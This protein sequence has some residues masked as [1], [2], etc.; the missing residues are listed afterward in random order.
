MKKASVRIETRPIRTYK[1]DKPSRYPILFA[2]GY[3][4]VYPY[5]M[6][7][8]LLHVAENRPYK[9]IVLENEYV[10]VTILPE[11]GGHL[12]SAHDKISGRDLFYNNQV[13]K[14]GLIALR[15]AWCATGIEWNFPVGHSVSTVSPVDH[16][17]FENADG[18]VTAVV[19]DLDRIT[20]MRW[21]VKI[22][23][24]PGELGFHLDTV[25]ANPTGA[26]HRYMY[27]EN[28]GVHAT[29]GLQF[30]SPAKV[31]WTWG[32]KRQFPMVDGVDKSWYV[33]HPRAIDY[34]MLG[35]GQDYYGYYDH[36]LRVGAVH[37]AD[38]HQMPGKKFFTWGMADAALRWQR[39]LTDDNGPYIE[40]QFG[41]TPTQASFDFFPPQ[42]ARR[43]DET[44]FGITDLGSFVHANRVAAVH[45]SEK[46]DKAPWPDE[47][48]AA[49]VTNRAFSNAK[50]V[51]KSGARTVFSRNSLALS[52]GAPQRWKVKLPSGARELSI[53]VTS[54]KDTVIE[55][56]TRDSAKIREL[57]Y[58]PITNVAEYEN[59]TP[60]KMLKAAISRLKWFEYE[61]ALEL[62]DKAL[63]KKAS[64]A[65]G[66][67]WKGYLLY[68]LMRFDEAARELARVPVRNEHYQ[69]AQFLLGQVHKHKG[70]FAEA[71]RSAEALVKT[72]SGARS[73]W[74]LAGEI[75]MLEGN[76]VAAAAAFDKAASAKDAAP[77]TLALYAVALR[78]SGRTQEALAQVRR[79]LEADPLE[80]LALNESEV[81][82]A[83]CERDERMRGQAESYIEL[84]SY[85]EASGLFDE[86]AAVLEHFRADVARGACTP[87]V[88]YHL[89]RA[90]EQLG[91]RSETAAFYS[92]AAATNPDHAFPFRIEDKLA[93]EAAIRHNASDAVAHYLLGNLL[94]WRSQGQEA[95]A[96]WRKALVGMP[97]YAVLLRNMALYHK[98]RNEYPKAVAL[99][100]RA[101]DSAPKDDE[102]YVEADD[103]CARLGKLDARI[104]LLERGLKAL[105]N[106][107]KVRLLLAQTY[108]HAARYD[109]ALDLIMHKEFDHWEGDRR[110]HQVFVLSHM[111]RGKICLRNKAYAEAVAEFETAMQYPANLKVGKPAFPRH[112]PQYYMIAV[113]YEAVSD[114]EKAAETYRLGADEIH[115]SWE[116]SAC[117]EA[118][119]K[120]LCLMKLDRVREAKTLLRHMTRGV[121]HWGF[122]A[123][124]DSF[125]RGLG[126]Q[127]LGEWANAVKHLEAALTADRT[128]TK[129]KYQL[130]QARKHRQAGL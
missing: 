2:G 94:A 43:W 24:K 59:G 62:I 110:G 4:F 50:V 97:K 125:V 74:Q 119:F 7:D 54:G 79:A 63:R 70:R 34:F 128:N 122:P 52:P 26:P 101:I 38:Y 96:H 77:H 114:K 5:T 56:S 91:R 109:D 67:Y 73:G 120:A 48:E 123:W 6:E 102:L 98:S 60:D 113:A 65:D 32:G 61:K 93:L 81:L 107:Q 72:K 80:F 39:N 76:Y 19:G 31:A 95:L 89:G 111:E 1:W 10:K 85:Y 64:F 115:D 104:A 20:R 126:Y 27:W 105:P 9:Q 58:D 41:L 75:A 66:R 116:G 87:L 46:F 8:R 42:T 13:V 3:R 106:S 51:L 78:K 92:K 47:V 17:V 45:F 29:E 49:V 30:I 121:E 118:Y 14:P 100:K 124:Y 40:L 103:V 25:L 35:I 88:Y 18:S 71:R 11:L 22:T 57:P 44:W 83:R 129:V 55:Y 99:Y 16:A 90:N 28:V 130:A 33:A 15:G 21:T 112:A 86:A 127:G 37:I 23:V 68:D 69:T 12:W 108:Y 84:A 117:E 53:K 36:K 82:G